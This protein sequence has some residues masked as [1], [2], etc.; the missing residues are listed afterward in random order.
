MEN[1]P[2]IISV[3]PHVK[4][5]TTTA[6]IMLYVILALLPAALLS[7]YLYKLYAVQVLFFSLV[8]ALMTEYLF[9]KYMKLS[10]TLNNLSAIV[11]GLLLALTLPP[12]IPWWIAFIGGIIAIGLGKQVFGGLGYN[13]FNPALVARAILLLSWPKYMTKAWYKTIAVDSVSKATPLYLAKEAR[14]GLIHFGTSNF[15]K[16]FL[17][18]NTSGTLGEVSVILLL[19]GG[20][21]LIYM[22]IIDWRIPLSYIA[23]TA[24]LTVFMKGDPIFYLLAGGLMLGAFFMATDYVTSPITRKGRVIF[25]IGCGMVTVLLRF[26]SS[27]PEGVMFSIL[28][29]NACAPL[30]DKYT[31]PKVFGTKT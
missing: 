2:L 19:A 3:S 18:S 5:E 8:S 11:T 10:F 30:I 26:Y 12:K 21:F 25:G 16:T 9:Q 20:I 22:K 31:Q 28:F 1:K 29:M 7:I 23:T 13:L 27:L 4:D 14:E 15:Y 24:V 17:F 6:K